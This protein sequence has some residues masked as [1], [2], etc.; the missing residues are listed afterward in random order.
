MN[1]PF[2]IIV[3]TGRKRRWLRDWRGDVMRFETGEHAHEV[4]DSFQ[5]LALSR[6]EFEIFTVVEIGQVARMAA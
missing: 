3:V 1:K 6:P 4:A 5:F 2:R